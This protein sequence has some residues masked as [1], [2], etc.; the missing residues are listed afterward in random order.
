MSNIFSYKNNTILNL[1]SN[2][3][4]INEKGELDLHNLN[5]KQALFAVFVFLLTYKHGEAVII[6]GK[7]KH[8]NEGWPKLK[9]TIEQFLTLMKYQFKTA[10][11]EKGGKGALIVLLRGSVIQ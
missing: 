3:L 8:S 11:I 5:V 4:P 10:P 7:G 1:F 6:T 9:P 2:L